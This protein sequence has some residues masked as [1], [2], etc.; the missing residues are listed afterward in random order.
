MLSGM[1][2]SPFIALGLVQAVAAAALAAGCGSQAP[3]PAVARD[4]ENCVDRNE[5]VV[6]DEQCRQEQS[7]IGGVGFVPFYHAYYTRGVQPLPIGQPAAGGSL[8]RAAGS[9]PVHP[10]AFPNVSRGGFGSTGAS[11]SS[12]AGS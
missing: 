7:S 4:W 8:F 2:R 11:H 9:I 5:R 12:S 3:A 1:K 6:S 10:S